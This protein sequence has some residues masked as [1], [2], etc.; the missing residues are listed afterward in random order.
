MNGKMR[1]P[2]FTAGASIYPSTHHYVMTASAGPVKDSGLVSMAACNHPVSSKGQ[3]CFPTFDPKVNISVCDCDGTCG[4]CTNF[5]FLGNKQICPCTLPS[6][7][8]PP[9][10]GCP[11]HAP[12]CCGGL[13]AQGRCTEGCIN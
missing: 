8:P 4:T 2:G 9:P 11:P 1:L 6:P 12:Y 10:V 5:D 7:P 3:T 13:D